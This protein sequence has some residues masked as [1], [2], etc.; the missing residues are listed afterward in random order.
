MK[1]LG[2]NLF[3]AACLVAFS[4]GC[5]KANEREA[6]VGKSNFEGLIG[7]WVRPDG[8]YVIEIK[9]VDAEGTVDLSYFNPRPINVGR[10]V[11]SSDAAQVSL[12][13]ELRDV[14]KIFV[15]QFETLVAQHLGEPSQMCVYGENCGKAIA[16]E[17]DGSLYSCD[18]YV[19]PDFRIGRIQDGSLQDTVLSREQVK[20]G[21][22]KS[23]ALPKYCRECPHVSDCRGECPKNRIIRTPDGEAGLNYLCRGLKTFFAHAVPEVERIV[24]DLRAGP[25]ASIRRV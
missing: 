10:A 12:T 18:H 20:F 13:V 16:I 17:H 11:V 22:A 19:Y 4:S 25:S 15:N 23:E 5:G 8:G 3:L 7:R 1:I 2:L 24:A 9:G 21:Y 6:P 14:G